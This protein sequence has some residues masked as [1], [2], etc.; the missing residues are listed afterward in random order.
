MKRQKSK[1]EER[2]EAVEVLYTSLKAKQPVSKEECYKIYD[3][4]Q[5]ETSASDKSNNSDIN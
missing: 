4:M 2:E 3:R 1:E 5:K